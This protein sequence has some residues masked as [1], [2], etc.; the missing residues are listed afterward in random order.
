[1]KYKELDFT[2][3]GPVGKGKIK[4]NKINVFFGSNNSGKSLV[5]KLI[6]AIN[7]TD[8]STKAVP[9]KIRQILEE[10]PKNSLSDAY[11]YSILRKADI[12]FDDVISHGMSKCSINVKSLHSSMGF[13]IKTN[14]ST[15]PSKLLQL[16]HFYFNGNRYTNTHDTVYIPAGR[17]GIIQ[18]F[19][20]I[21]DGRNRLLSELL[22][23][24]EGNGTT[25][26]DKFTVKSIKNFMQSFRL[27]EYL[28]QF[29]NLM[30]LAQVDNL[31]KNIQKLFS[32]VFP[33]KIKI[34]KT[35]TGLTQVDYHDSTGFVTKLELA[36][37]GV[38]SW[39]P[40]SVG[41][42][43]VKPNGTLIVEEPEIHL[44]PFRQ[45]NLI[46]LLQ[47][48]AHEKKVNL[49]FT[50]HSDYIVKKLLAM[51]SSKKIKHSDLGLYYFNRTDNLTNI[52]Q[53]DVDKYGEAEQP[54]FQT[55]MDELIREFSI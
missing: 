1:M 3:F 45:L 20:Q 23:A 4:P 37:S 34:V 42:H 36:G 22:N 47:R 14:K 31:D 16:M 6:Y 5:A 32:K 49:I 39:F 33:G 13:V 30:L 51:V 18:T 48:T 27:P 12:S 19:K 50:T 10:S 40:I 35:H 44:E 11:L 41:M 38:V 21:N 2:N 24:F 26:A 43:Y 29:Y 7:S 9:L 28:E 55:A 15:I 8:I 25:N 17:T 54:I 52:E 46:E 53:I